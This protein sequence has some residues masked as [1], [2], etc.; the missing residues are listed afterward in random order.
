MST[1]P[2]FNAELAAW[3][4]KVLAESGTKMQR[5]ILTDLFVGFVDGNPV[6]D[7]RLWKRRAPPDYEGGHSKRN[8]RVYLHRDYAAAERAGI[9]PTGS[10]VK[11]EAAAVIGRIR[12]KPVDFATI[13]NPVEYMDALAN[14][15]SK[16][17]PAGWMEQNVARVSAKYARV[18]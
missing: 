16:Q 18:R 9:D 14:G 4:Q 1:L 5:D 7:P 3:P 13:S 10:I 6:G 8:W 11:A 2:Q 17:A 15:W 12:T